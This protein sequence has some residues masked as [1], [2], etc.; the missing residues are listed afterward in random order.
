[1]FEPLWA[2]Q[3]GAL[4]EEEWRR[5]FEGSKKAANH[6]L[7]ALDTPRVLSILFDRLYVL[8]NQLV[9]GGATWAGAVNR[10]QITQGADIMG[11]LVP[12][13]I[14]LMM[15]NPG[16]LWGDAVYPVVT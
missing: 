1:M 10:E 4:G 9:H 5:S 2:A 11:Q 12:I 7:A 16:E 8:R 3:R 13:V 14:H 6:A 15:M